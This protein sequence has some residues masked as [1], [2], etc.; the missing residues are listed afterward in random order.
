VID[1]A[2]ER[3]IVVCDD[4]VSVAGR[5]PLMDIAIGPALLQRIAATGGPETLRLYQPRPTLAFS[6]RDAATPGIAT[7]AAAARRAGFAPLRRGPGGRAAAYHRGALCIDHVGPDVQGPSQIK[8]RFIQY[9]ELLVRALRTVGVDAALGPVPGEYCPGEYSINDGHGHKLVGTAQRLV[10][11]GALFG[12]VIL[13]ADPEPIREVL[14]VV[15]EA[16]GLSWDPGTVGAVQTAAPGVT[17][18][19]VHAALLAE[20]ARLG[21]LRPA[22]LPVDALDLA[23]ARA[24]RHLLPAG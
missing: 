6:G 8:P 5:E 9:G 16:L 15:Y 13:L 21:E 24:G 22:E 4:T 23:G 7:A 12:T 1:R 11:G 2:V 10:R 14:T 20:Y 3:A 17:M 19:D 18:D